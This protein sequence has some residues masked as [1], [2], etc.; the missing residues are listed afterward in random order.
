M[1]P[2]FIH[3]VTKRETKSN[4]WIFFCKKR[5]IA[6]HSRCMSKEY[7]K[8]EKGKNKVPAVET[9]ECFM[10]NGNGILTIFATS[11]K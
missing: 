2:R 1:K 6:K 11:V 5:D 10:Y 3:R 7:E 9:G 8:K 4:R